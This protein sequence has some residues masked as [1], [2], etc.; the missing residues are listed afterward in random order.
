MCSLQ[1][2]MT[3]EDQKA[4]GRWCCARGKVLASIKLPRRGFVPGEKIPITALVDNQSSKFMEG[5]TLRLVKT[6]SYHAPGPSGYKSYYNEKQ[7]E[8]EIPIATIDSIG[9]GK[10]G[11]FVDCEFV[12]PP[13]PPSRLEGCKNIDVKYEMEAI[14]QTDDS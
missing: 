5:A 13:L 3:E 8:E 6:E 10:T 12:V 4:I 14:S 1:K 11:E 9:P 2:P 7:E